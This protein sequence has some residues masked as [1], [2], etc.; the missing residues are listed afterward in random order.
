MVKSLK[1]YH[2]SLGNYYQSKQLFIDEEIFG[3]P[4]IRKL[5]E[6]PWQF[7]QSE[8]WKKLYELLSNLDFIKVSWEHNKFDLKIYWTKTNSNYKQSILNAYDDVILNPKKYRQYLWPVAILLTDLRYLEESI[9]LKEYLSEYHRQ[10]NDMLN[11]QASLGNTAVSLIRLGRYEKA[12][13]LLRKQLK[14]C[15]EIS[16]KDIALPLYNLGLIFHLRYEPEKAMELYEEANKIA[17]EYSNLNVKGLSIG[18]RAVIHREMGDP[19]QAIKFHVEEE[20]IFRELYD[21][22][23]LQASLGNQALAY[24][25]I[26]DTEKAKSRFEQQQKICRQIGNYDDL[27]NSLYNEAMMY[28]QDFDR[29]DK[30]LLLIEEAYKIAIEKQMKVLSRELKPF[31]I[32]L[33][34]DVSDTITYKGVSNNLESFSEHD[35]IRTKFCKKISWWRKIIS[36]CKRAI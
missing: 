19:E 10:N 33:R 30:A 18:K 1:E 12:E 13:D 4:N 34:N 9:I 11:Q 3:R 31:L 36:K 25:M 6:Q 26:S 5:V 29:P 20:M 35:E 32:Q 24:V 28:L 15:K 16:Y 22:D 14:L 21:L 2:Q 8:D 17:K 23:G 27:F 7:S